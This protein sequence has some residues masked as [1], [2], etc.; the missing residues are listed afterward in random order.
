[1]HILDFRNPPRYACNA[2]L[3]VGVGAMGVGKLR[4]A[5][6]DAFVFVDA[7]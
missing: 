3:L 7:S 1:M 4:K 5:S 6:T 2:A